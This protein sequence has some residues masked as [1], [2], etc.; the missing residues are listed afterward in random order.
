M[1]DGLPPRIPTIDEV[2]EILAKRIGVHRLS[3][4]MLV[5][6]T[7]DQG[8]RFSSYGSTN[9]SGA[10][11]VDGE[12]LF[13]IGSITKLFTALV[14][15]DM[16][17]KRE[18][19][20]D[21]NV[22]DFLPAG[23]RVPERNG[24]SI[25]LLD[26]VTHRSGLPRMPSDFT[27]ERWTNPDDPYTPEQLYRFFETHSLSRTP[28]DT[29]VYSNLGFALLGHAL[30]L[31]AGL[32][33]EALVRSRVL[34]PLRMQRTVITVPEHL[35]GNVATGHDDALDAV[36]AWSFGVMSGAGALRSSAED[37]L[38]FLDALRDPGTSPLADAVATLWR[39][40]AEGGL[41]LARP[42]PEG[43]MLLEHSGGTG[44]FRSYAACLPSWERG[45]VV[46]SNAAI[47]ATADLG[48]HLLDTRYRLMWYRTQVPVEP[49]HLLRL[50]GRYRLTPN[51]IFDVT[52]SGDRLLVQLTGQKTYRVFPTSDWTFY[53]KCVGAQLTF[54]PGE[55]N[56]AARV[57][58]H[59]ES[60][61]QIA[62]RIG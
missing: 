45:I 48:L 60:R 6:I 43:G 51:F 41:G 22:Q 5:G 17:S 32:D 24:R 18:V 57:I 55:D 14:L 49:A 35:S 38:L 37:V 34:V 15:A 25:T 46:L 36:P 40:H 59:Q 3:R 54:E 30:G 13:E 12:T 58:L 33:Y 31:K 2:R 56:R 62:E 11:P 21:Q 61:D 42:H 28:G 44:G 47:E 39:P 9:A 4:G 27:I 1:S 52:S 53:Y 8:H 7:D 16:V 20:I 29:E 19:A 10:R 26:L 23:V 50:T